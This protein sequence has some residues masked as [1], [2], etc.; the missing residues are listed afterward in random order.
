V[1]NAVLDLLGH[2]KWECSVGQTGEPII[3][4]GQKGRSGLW[5]SVVFHM[6]LVVCFL[7]GPVTVLTHFRGELIL[8]EG[9]TIP[10][11]AGFE[12]HSGKDP[13]TLPDVLV[14]VHNLRG[15]YF[16]G[17]YNYDFGGKLAIDDA[18]DR[19]DIPFAVNIPADFRGYEFQL[20]EFGYSPHIIID[21]DGVPFFDYFLNLRHPSE[22]DYFEIGEGLR[23]SIM[24]FPD[25]IKEGGKISSK[26]KRPD[27][28]V[29]M[30]K[31]FRGDQEVFK[32]LFK[33]GDEYAF[34]EYRIKSPD[35]KNWV[36]LIVVRETGILF[37]II[38]FVLGTT[39]LLVRFLSNERRTEVELA[40]APEGTRI[41]IS[42]FSRYYPAFLEKEVREMA[43]K[44]KSDFKLQ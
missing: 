3:I 17:K 31:I 38:G 13:A 39:G 5:G 23:A 35:Y 40:A 24:F 9:E 36:N 27:N 6:G 1:K 28:P 32:G 25:F 42:G 44:L 37:V 30:V 22:G 7:A 8:T 34:G 19:F 43:Q 20:H 12:S 41:T 11:R 2:G 14:M 18:G 16:K 29:T 15:V 33:P 4:S 26:S 21:K 10:L